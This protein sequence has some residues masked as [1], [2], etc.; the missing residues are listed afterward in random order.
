MESRLRRRREEIHLLE[1]GGASE[2]DILAAKAKY[3]ALSDE[4]AEFSKAFDLPQQRER[5]NVDG[6]LNIG[7]YPKERILKN[8]VGN[9]IILVSKSKIRFAPN[10]ITQVVNKRGGITRNYY[11]ATGVQVKQISNND[12]GHIKESKLGKHGEHAHD[13]HYDIDKKRIVH[14]EARELTEDERKEN[15]DII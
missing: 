2:D 14:G 4:Y 11:G 7:K 13:Y 5:V 12:H 6:L 3:H 1:K 9:D 10:T 15:A 8:A